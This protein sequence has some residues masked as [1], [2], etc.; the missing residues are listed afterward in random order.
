MSD[1]PVDVDAYLARLGYAGDRAPTLTTLA[2]LQLAHLRAVPFENL[3]VFARRGVRV[4]LAHS[5]HKVVARRGGGWCFELNG[6]FSAL[7]GALGFDVTRH[8][9][10][11][12]SDDTLG[13]PLDHLAL[14]VHLDGRRWL[15]DVGFGD[16]P[17]A[18][19][20]LDDP[21]PQDGLVRRSCLAPVDEV[22]GHVEL[23]DEVGGRW[24]R[25]HRL[26]LT[27]RRLD[28]FA[29]RSTFLQTEPGLAWT[30]RR[31]VTWPTGTGRVWLLSDRLKVRVGGGD[32]PVTETPVEPDAWEQVLLDTFGMVLDP[33]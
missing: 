14:V 23:L 19:L 9:A 2:A 31:F 8:S 20:D 18:P 5:L 1:P 22:P 28:E 17:L 21:S 24:V 16:A 33:A 30:A 27:P 25:K 29:A 26:D 3:D 15:V 12:D 4:D 10:Q 32:G 6:A 11:V 13:P 7:L